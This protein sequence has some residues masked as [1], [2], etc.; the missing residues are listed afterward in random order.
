MALRK[1]LVGAVATTMA[2]ALAVPAAGETVEQSFEDETWDED[3]DQSLE[4]SIDELREVHPYLVDV[5]TLDM[6]RTRTQRGFRGRGLEVVIPPGGW[7]GFGPYARLPEPADEAWFRYYVYLSDFRPVSS[8]KL[9]GPADASLTSSAKGCKPSTE[10][11]PGWSARMMF[12]TLGTAG[13][14]PGEVPIGYYLYHLGQEGDCGDEL[15]FGMGLEQRRWTCIEGHVE[16]NTPGSDDGSI[17]AWVD[18]EQVFSRGG[19]E[20]RRPGEP[21]GVR[22]MWDNV[23]FGGRDPTPN[24]LGLVLD[25]IVVDTGGRLGCLDPFVDDNESV[26]EGDL[27]ELHARNLLFGCGERLACPFDRLT[28]A[29]FA[30]MLQRVMRTPSGPDAFADDDGHWAEG[31]IDSLARAGILRGCDPPANSR[32]CPDEPVTRGQVAA[33]VR[34]MLSLPAA[35]EDAF[36]DDDGHWAEGDIDAIAAADITRGCEESRYCPQRDMTRG[37]A[38]TF[39][40]RIDDRLRAVQTLAPLPDWPPEGPPPPKPPEERE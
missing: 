13:A 19:L 37:E 9:P 14:G 4:D 7:R 16:M 40:L 33:M 30:A 5:R 23:Y 15:M 21:L 18:G 10:T 24:R 28:R 22:E 3:P 32:A 2:V 12:D 17:R 8:G 27:T 1:L 6:I 38:G 29:E 26:H 34:R 35:G 25:E 39:T 20:F 36:S 31:A 11:A